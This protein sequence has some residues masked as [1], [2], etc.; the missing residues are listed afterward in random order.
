MRRNLIVLAIVASGAVLGWLGY[1]TQSPQWIL[2][3]CTGTVS[4]V[5]GTAA[6]PC[7]PP[8]NVEIPL[9]LGGAISWAIGGALLGLALAGLALWL[10]IE[11]RERRWARPLPS[12]LPER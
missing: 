12:D 1:W 9:D 8:A 5:G 4:A 6:T 2:G 7:V 3:T 10:T 11:V